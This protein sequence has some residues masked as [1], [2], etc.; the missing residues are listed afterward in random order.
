VQKWDTNKGELVNSPTAA[1][2]GRYAA[3]FIGIS[4]LMNNSFYETDL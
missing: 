3:L 4:L 1:I 2:L